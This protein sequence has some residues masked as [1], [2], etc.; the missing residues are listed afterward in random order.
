MY[1]GEAPDPRGGGHPA[2]ASLGL[3]LGLLLMLGLPLVVETVGAKDP[4]APP[5]RRGVVALE[6]HVVMVMEVRA[7]GWIEGVYCTE[8]W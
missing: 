2:I 8:G 4:V 3:L 5:E 1:I 7:C 6:D